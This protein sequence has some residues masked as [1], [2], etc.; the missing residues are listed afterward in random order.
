MSRQTADGAGLL[1]GP[2][3]SL[4]FSTFWQDDND[5]QQIALF[6]PYIPPVTAARHASSAL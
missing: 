5:F 1:G 6:L 2:H 3:E 4:P